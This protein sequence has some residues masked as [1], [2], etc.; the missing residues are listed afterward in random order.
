MALIPN[1]LG[2]LIGTE[3]RKTIQVFRENAEFQAAR[4]HERL[5]EAMTQYGHEFQYHNRGG[6][7]RWM[8]ALNRLPRPAMAFGVLGL[9]VAAMVDPVWFSGHMSGLAHVPDPLWWL[10]GAIVSFY[11]GA[12]YQTKGAE[13]RQQIAQLNRTQHTPTVPAAGDENAA[14]RDWADNQ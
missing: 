3:A 9:F 11:F 5:S 4:D 14:I 13:Y 1:L 6:F 2:M 12:R 10:L 7:D 8:D